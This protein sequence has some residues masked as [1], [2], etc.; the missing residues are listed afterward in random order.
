MDETME[1]AGNFLPRL[2]QDS[3]SSAGV[4]RNVVTLTAPASVAA[5]Q[6]RTLYFRLERLK[7]VRSMKVVAI[8]S[9]I[10]GEG[11]T[12]TAVNLALAAARASLDRRILL[13]DADLRRGRVAGLLGI[14]SSPGLRELLEGD[15]EVRDVVRRFQGERL[16]VVPAGT[17]SPE[18]T[19]ALA[20]PRMRQLLE[21][22]RDH[23][24][25]VYI[26][27]PPTLP[28]AD[29]AILGAQADGVLMVIRANQTSARHV[30]TAVE[31]LAGAPIVGCVLN[32]SDQAQASYLSWKEPRN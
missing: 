6:F 30:R 26:D 16:A 15:A 9:A 28:F 4:D 21:R 10:P 31:M 7:Q 2:D 23:F 22:V 24:D 18:P 13:L 25:E 14:R 8:T 11:K 27:A 17:S 1:R 12:V 20:S 32:G 5:E 3:F 19:G 29:A